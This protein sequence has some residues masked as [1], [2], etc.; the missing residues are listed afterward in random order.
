MFL[1]NY[2]YVAAYS[3][4]VTRKPLGRVMLGEPVVVYRRRDGTPVALEDRCAHRRLPL[5]M[6]KVIGDDLQCHYHSVVFDCTGAC[7]NIPGQERIPR[8]MRVKSYPVVDRPPCV[9]VWMGDEAD[10]DESLIPTHFDM[11]NRDGWANSTFHGHV[12]GNYQLVIDNLLDLSHLAT[13]HASTVG[14]SHVAD[15]AKV[16]TER[17]GDNVTVSRWTMDVPAATTYQQFGAYEGNIDRWQVSEFFP[18]SYFRINNG[19]AAVG[20]GARQGKGDKRWDFWVCHG[21]TPSTETS[22]HYFWALAHEKWPK[23]KKKDIDDFHRQCHH[24]IGEDIEVFVEQQKCINLD[25]ASPEVD[26]LY[27]AGPLAARRIIDKLLKK[28]TAGRKKGRKTAR[29]VA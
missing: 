23:T 10:A 22:T 25:P 6:G 28:E 20:T 13:V 8:K 26:I 16:E 21:I 11:L 4:E 3:T 27:D 5:S 18:P 2:W 15:I 14:T 9:F 12:E 19:A 29:K 1:R 17:Q 7:V 24:V